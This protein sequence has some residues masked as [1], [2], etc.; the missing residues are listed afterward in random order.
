MIIAS[1]HYL[2]INPWDEVTDNRSLWKD[3]SSDPVCFEAH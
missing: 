1:V 3:F 2:Y